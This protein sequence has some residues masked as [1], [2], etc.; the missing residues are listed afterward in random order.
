MKDILERL[1]A[2]TVAGSA[3]DELLMEAGVL[4]EIGA[5]EMIGRYIVEANDLM[6]EAAE[7]I[8]RLRA[9]HDDAGK[10]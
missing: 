4:K 1:Y 7:E 2:C 5:P 6:R 8:R 9:R 10:A 3:R